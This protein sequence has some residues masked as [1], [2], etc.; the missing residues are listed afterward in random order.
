MVLLLAV[1]ILQ[2]TQP[3][4]DYTSKTYVNLVLQATLPGVKRPQCM[5]SAFLEDVATI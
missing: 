2:F 5:A 1:S 4:T 3:R